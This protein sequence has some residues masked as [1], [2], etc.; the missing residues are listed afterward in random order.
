MAL[1]I[2]QT[3]VLFDFHVHFYRHIESTQYY[4]ANELTRI[5]LCFL[6]SD[7][8][9]N[10]ILPFFP[11]FFPSFGINQNFVS[12]CELML[13]SDIQLCSLNWPTR[14]SWERTLITK[15]PSSFHGSV[16]PLP[17]KQGPD[18]FF[19]LF[20]MIILMTTR[21]FFF[22]K[23]ELLYCLSVKYFL[24]APIWNFLNFVFF[25]CRIKT[26]HQNWG[27]HV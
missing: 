8:V 27:K 6:D 2:N 24:F 19:I 11:E 22:G 25:G 13:N 15:D 18:H 12:F 16:N 23:F 26:I 20:Y 3:P 4:N 21:E 7:E 5:I 1:T 10:S 9:I 17:L 14:A